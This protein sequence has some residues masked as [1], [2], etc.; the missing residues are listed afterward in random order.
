M[1]MLKWKSHNHNDFPI[2]QKG[3]SIVD[4]QIEVLQN[5]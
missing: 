4:R 2:L 1:A 3:G 5:M